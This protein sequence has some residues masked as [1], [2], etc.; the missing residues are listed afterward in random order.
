MLRWTACDDVGQAFAIARASA[1]VRH[2]L[3][4]QRRYCRHCW[5]V[6]TA[7]AHRRYASIVVINNCAALAR[8]G[9]VNRPHNLSVY[10][11]HLLLLLLPLLLLLMLLLSSSWLLRAP[12]SEQRSQLKPAPSPHI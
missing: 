2:T 10:Q 8:L 11:L 4:D 6:Y 1:T 3:A 7:S 12:H 5:G 9:F